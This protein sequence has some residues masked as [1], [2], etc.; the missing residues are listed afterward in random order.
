MAEEKKE[1]KPS[2]VSQG[3]IRGLQLWL[4]FMFAFAFLGYSRFFSIVL[5]TIAGVAGGLSAAWW[6][7][8]DIPTP[9]PTFEQ[10]KS[11]AN[12]T[13]ERLEKTE[14]QEFKKL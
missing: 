1:K 4:F 11:L 7:M 3:I 13:K 5:G 9:K 6:Q 8:T 10:Q 12:V 14:N 2:P